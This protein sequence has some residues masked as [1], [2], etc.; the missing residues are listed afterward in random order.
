MTFNRNFLLFSL[1]FVSLT[2]CLITDSART[3]QLEIMKPGLIIIPEDL[4]TVAILNR[5]IYQS[6][7]SDFIYQY[8]FRLV[9]D[10]T[11]NDHELSTTCVDALSGF[12]EKEA[13]F[14]KVIN[15]RDS[16]NHWW[17]N[18]QTIISPSDLFEKTKSD[19]CIFLDF[20][21]LNN[22][23]IFYPLLRTEAYLRWTIAFKTDTFAYIYNQIDTLVYEPEDLPVSFNS[24]L[25]YEIKPILN[26]T[27]EYLGRYFG[28]KIIPSWL[29]VERIYY[30]SSNHNM[31]NAE[32]FAL[33]ND[34][35]KAAEIWNKETK[36]KNLHIAVKASYNMALACEMEGNYDAGIDW[37]VKSYS[38]MS[39]N[40]VEH[41][42]NCQRYLNILA[43]RKREIEKLD[44]Q[45]REK[46][47]TF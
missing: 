19:I 44:Q 15:Y 28:T 45:V 20:F 31:L 39:K 47:V 22:T 17:T 4:N 27:S 32:K 12:L 46:S 37:L 10:T 5:D 2:S 29:P 3:I 9:A 13:Y 40:N 18:D 7:T 36:N 1:V 33:H 21:S 6:D 35:L 14:R 30:N 38:V 34:W 42:A 11:I 26:N 25:K 16:L 24:R 8:N 23:T 43:L 41:R